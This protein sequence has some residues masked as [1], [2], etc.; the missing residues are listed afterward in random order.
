MACRIHSKKYEKALK[1]LAE[2]AV[3]QEKKRGW[4]EANEDVEFA[5]YEQPD[6]T[7]RFYLLNIRWWDR[8]ESNVVFCHGEHR[9]TIPV[10]FG[11]IVEFQP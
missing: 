7:R 1:E 8:R 4:F 10:P 5:C 3:A 2:F 9:E 6:G 11:N